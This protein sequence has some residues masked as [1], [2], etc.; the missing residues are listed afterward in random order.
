M[1]IQVVAFDPSITNF[2]SCR[3]LVDID[4]LK[5]TIEALDICK[6]ESDS[7]KG[8]KKVSDDLRRAKLVLDAMHLLCQGRALAIAEIPL[9][10]AAQYRDAVM[11]AGMM[12]GILASCRLPLIQVFPQDVKM[13]VLGKR[14]S[15][16]EEMIEWGMEKY[17]GAP[18]RMRRVKAPG[19]HSLVPTA[20]NEHLADAIAVLECDRHV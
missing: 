17:P 7:K 9:G 1:N 20:D 14:N 11:N 5:I 6:T 3:A 19:G 15:S 13:H 8:V 10:T 18:W 2:G 4:T 16:K 12:T